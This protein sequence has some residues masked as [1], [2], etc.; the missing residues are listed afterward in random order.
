MAHMSSFTRLILLVI[1]VPSLFKSVNQGN[2]TGDR[3]NSILQV[4]GEVNG[5]EQNIRTYASRNSH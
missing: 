3:H 2:K 5:Y 1:V 4:T